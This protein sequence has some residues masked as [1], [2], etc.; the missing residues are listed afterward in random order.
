[1]KYQISWSQTKVKVKEINDWPIE[2]TAGE[3]EVE[4]TVV[5]EIKM[6]SHVF[7]GEGYDWGM[8]LLKVKGLEGRGPWGS[9][10][11][12]TGTKSETQQHTV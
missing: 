8:T 4:L 7:R 1:L 11:N 3:A 6:N 5:K 9:F 2:K 10:N 12:V